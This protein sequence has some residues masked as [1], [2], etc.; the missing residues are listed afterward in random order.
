MTRASRPPAVTSAAVVGAWRR[1]VSMS[2][3]P[4]GA[5]SRER[6]PR[7][8]GARRARRFRRRVPLAPR[9]RAPRAASSRSR[10]WARTARSRRARPPGRAGRAAAHREVARHHARTEA[11]EVS[12]GGQHSGQVEVGGGELTPSTAS[13]TAAPIARLRS[14]GRRPRVHILIGDHRASR[15]AS[16]ASASVRRR[17][18]NTP[19][20]RRIGVAELRPSEELLERFP[21]DATRDEPLELVRGI[22]TTLDRLREQQRLVLGED[23]AGDAQARDNRGR[24]ASAGASSHRPCL[25]R[26]RRAP[27]AR[28]P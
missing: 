5:S 27:V 12:A 28:M 20:S 10:P 22:R 23:A 1:L 4:P 17:G 15:T 11:L 18:T 14:T 19:G 24:A 6:M 13:T 8:D 2:R 26:H 3:C 25:A 7:R 9:G 21:V 16:A